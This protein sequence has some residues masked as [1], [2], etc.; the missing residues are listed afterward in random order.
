MQDSQVFLELI[1]SRHSKR[2][3]LNEPVPRE[4]LERVLRAAAEA[5]SSKNTQPWGVAVLSGASREQL[6]ELLC[7]KFD[8][9]EHESPDYIYHAEPLHRPARPSGA[10]GPHA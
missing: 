6:S 10:G 4:L 9:G 5:P 8:R 3:Y 2:A 7:A 1:R